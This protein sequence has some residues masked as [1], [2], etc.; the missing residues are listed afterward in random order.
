MG[1]IDDIIGFRIPDLPLPRILPC[2]PAFPIKI[3]FLP[4]R[5]VTPSPPVTSCRPGLAKYMPPCAGFLT[6]DDSGVPSPPRKCCDAIEPLFESA[7]PLCLSHVVNGDSGELLP[8][9]VNHTRARP[10]CCT[11]VASDS[12]RTMLPTSAQIVTTRSRRWMPIRV[13][14]YQI[15]SQKKKKQSTSTTASPLNKG[16]IAII[17][18]S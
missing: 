13:H 5:N 1:L 14:L 12:H 17:S 3:P 15:C 7:S 10:P 18:S 16:W 6:S 2:P 9:L 4:C 8:A 11:S